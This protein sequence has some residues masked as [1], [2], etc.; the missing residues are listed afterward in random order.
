VLTAFLRYG[1]LHA[2]PHLIKA[3]V[4]IKIPLTWEKNRKLK[5]IW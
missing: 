4:L 2:A 1:A 3:G 5:V